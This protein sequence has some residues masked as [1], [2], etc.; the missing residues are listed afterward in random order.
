M[1]LKSRQFVSLIY[2]MALPVIWSIVGL[3]F[4]YSSYKI[5][6]P[7]WILNVTLMIA[8]TWTIGKFNSIK[9]NQDKLPNARIGALFIIP[10][11]LISMFAG[12]G[13]PPFDNPSQWVSSATEQ[14]V[15]YYF[16]IVAGVL[17]ALA[18]TLL[19]H[20]LK[21]ADEKFYSTIGS[22][23]IKLAIPIFLFNQTY[24]GFYYTRLSRLMEE[25]DMAKMPDWAIP[26]S[27]QYY[28]SD[29][30][31]S[32]LV[33]LGTAFFVASLKRKGWFTKPA[34][35]I[36]IALCVFCL[37]VDFLPG[38]FPKPWIEPFSTLNFFVSIPAVPF[39][40]SYYMG[41]NM[42]RKS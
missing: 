5:Y 14:R 35:N 40:I 2:L 17:V 9:D 16:L 15:R 30:I 7:L 6:L 28:Y 20:E 41:I 11:M 1:S 13:E 29:V 3:V 19:D 33:Y 10:F 27:S 24:F 31:V 26:L 8:C 34:S 4:G 12:L 25:A 42:L 23:A 21:K 18:F 22:L 36:Y 38:I 39:L 32:A 37:L